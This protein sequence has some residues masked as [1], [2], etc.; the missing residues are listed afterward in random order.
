LKAKLNEWIN[1]NVTFFQYAQTV[2]IASFLVQTCVTKPLKKKKLLCMKERS[3]C[4]EKLNLSWDGVPTADHFT[5]KKILE[6]FNRENGWLKKIFFLKFI[7][8]FIDV[9]SL[10]SVVC[11]W[12][13]K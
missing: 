13:P 12:K 7:H 4:K 2:A 10:I 1:K 3:Y 6:I 8:K 9:G 11:C 5:M